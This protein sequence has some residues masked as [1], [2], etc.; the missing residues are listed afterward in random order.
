MVIGAALRLWQYLANNSLF[1]DEAALARNIIDRPMMSLFRA[2]DYAQSAPLGF[3]LVQKGIVT[4]LGTSEYTLRAFPF[5][6]GI[7]A[8]FLFWRVTSRVLSG[9]A[10]TFAV[11]LFSLGLPFIQFSSLVKQYSSDIAAATV[12]LL[13]AIEIR[14]RGVTPERAWV[15]GVIG[16]A[17]VWFSQPALFVLA[18]IGTGFVILVWTER[19]RT[20]ART[21]T[22]TWALWGLSALTAGTVALRTVLL[23]IRRSF[24]G[25]GPTASCRCRPRAC[26]T[27]FGCSGN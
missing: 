6:C 5:V 15:L 19:D 22:V 11:G 12:L 8:L 9:W 21:L 2:S 1:V 24:G 26:G 7:L 16:A 25:S 20:A 4:I 17:A 14:R 23:R 18:G 3:L 13:A 27:S 10:V